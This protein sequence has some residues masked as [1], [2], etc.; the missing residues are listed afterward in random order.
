[1]TYNDELVSV[2]YEIDTSNYR[3][4]GG[5]FG[6]PDAETRRAFYR[7]AADVFLGIGWSVSGETNAKMDDSH[8]F[9]HPKEIKGTVRGWEVGYIADYMR[10][11]KTFSLQ[12]IRMGAAA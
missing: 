10:H 6:F 9:I 1:M 8:L 3:D 4:E 2:K 7:D 12:N 11:A 5:Y